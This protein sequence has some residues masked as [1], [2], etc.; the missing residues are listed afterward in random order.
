MLCFCKKQGGTGR[1]TDVHMAIYIV[2]IYVYYICMNV[3]DA[4]N[5]KCTKR[6]DEKTFLRDTD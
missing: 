4:S 1:Q 6:Y 5:K 2:Y 3:W